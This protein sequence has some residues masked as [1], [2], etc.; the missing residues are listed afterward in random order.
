VLSR[1]VAA[2]TAGSIA[3]AIPEDCAADRTRRSRPSGST[4]SAASAV[5]S[6]AWVV[7]VVEVIG[8]STDS[9][10]GVVISVGA[11]TSVERS[12]ATR[13]PYVRT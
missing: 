13:R 10:V 8:T 11:Q 3:H 6:P 7:A 1:W 2:R 4:L 5:G 9:R 12:S